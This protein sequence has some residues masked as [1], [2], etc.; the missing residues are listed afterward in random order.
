MMS[1]QAT[2]A[3]GFHR[4]MRTQRVI[5]GVL[6]GLVGI[7]FLLPAIWMLL[8]SLRPGGDIIA[9][10][11]PLS[12]NTLIPDVWTLDNYAALFGP[13]RFGQAMMNSL[14]VAFASVVLGLA[15]TI[16]AAY[17]LSVFRFPGRELVFAVLVVGFMIPFEAI[18]IP[19]AQ[20]FTQWHLDNT[21]IGL[22]LPGIG[23]GLAIFNLRQFFLGVPGELH[24]AARVDGASELRTMTQVYLPLSVTPVINSALLIFLAQ[25]GAYLWPLLVV[26]DEKIQVAAIALSRTFSDTSFNFGQMFG[27]ALVISVIPA[28]LL[29][30]LQRYFTQ[31]V[32]TK[33]L[34]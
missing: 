26:S 7:L 29:L 13:L 33:G 8:G 34:K 1:A 31:S 27:G 22:I 3:R 11:S 9:S 21:Y 32:A 30:V 19:L 2:A 16:P 17:A 24:E 12:W 14:I 25:W 18:A 10:V 28:V 4:R 15:I 23:N 5:L 6:A 20:I